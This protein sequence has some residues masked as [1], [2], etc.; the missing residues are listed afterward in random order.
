MWRGVR[1]RT[2]LPRTRGRECGDGR[3]MEED[4][5]LRPGATDFSIDAIMARP[6]R[7]RNCKR[8]EDA[9]SPGE[10]GARVHQLITLTDRVDEIL[11][12]EHCDKEMTL[13]T[14]YSCKLKKIREKNAETPTRK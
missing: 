10:S 11:H 1:R 6:G 12:N 3:M 4:C 9:S 8:E 5:S 2:R 7:R 14:N 13:T